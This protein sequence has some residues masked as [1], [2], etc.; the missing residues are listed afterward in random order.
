MRNVLG[1]LAGG[2][3]AESQQLRRSRLLLGLT[4]VQAVTFLVMVSVFG[5][6]GSH[7]PTAVVN[8][9]GGRL[10]QRWVA[11]MQ[12][13]HHTYGVRSMTAEQARAALQKGDVA[14]VITIPRDF[15]RRIAHHQ[16]IRIPF[17]IDNVNADLTDDV[18]RGIPSAAVAFARENRL[19]GIRVAPAEVD[20]VRHEVDFVP[21]LV[22]SAL[23][24]DAFLV[25]GILAATAIA[26][27]FEA[28]TVTGL[29]LSPANPLVPLA[30]RILATSFVS[31]VAISVTALIVVVAYGAVPVHAG[32]MAAALI[33]CVAI[34]SC[35][36]AAIGA[37][38]KRTLPI[39]ALIF[40]LAL[41]LY[42]DSGSL[43]PQRFDGE[44]IWGI[45]HTSPVYYAVG[46]L[47]HAVHG[48]RV[49]PEPVALDFVALVG[50]ALLA[51]GVAYVAI[52]RN[53]RP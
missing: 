28:R 22:V 41:P 46:V 31:A 50:W 2:F 34:F 11:Q 33:V 5:L 37:L 44:L 52:R 45:G 25:A 4:F 15:S 13:A 30:G 21:Y 27:E 39:S 43:E 3:R 48:L 9:D 10:S 35:V 18:E 1:A 16:L 14:A 51:C 20:L 17:R 7:V 42:L 8:Q 26:R 40:G 23:A 24:L 12:A 32:E 38:L 53:V 29:R 47:Q 19:P 36:G 6:T 49:T